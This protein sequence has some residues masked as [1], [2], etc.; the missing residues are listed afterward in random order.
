[1]RPRADKANSGTAWLAEYLSRA[2]T[3]LRTYRPSEFSDSLQISAYTCRSY[4]YSIPFGI[5]ILTL[6]QSV[7]YNKNVLYKWARNVCG[8]VACVLPP[9][10]KLPSDVKSSHLA[11]R[12]KFACDSLAFFR[13]SARAFQRSFCGNVAQRTAMRC[14]TARCGKYFG[15]YQGG[16][17]V[18]HR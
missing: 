3:R 2:T 5:E 14:R 12:G 9:F 8:N 6:Y 1:M 13:L 18:L 11:H 16:N 17:D 10:A 4:R 7:W 15:I